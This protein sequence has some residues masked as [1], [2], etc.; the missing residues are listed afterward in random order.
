MARTPAA[1]PSIR[2]T[3]ARAGRTLVAAALAIGV[4]GL[5]GA[6]VAGASAP[7]RAG[8][9][10]LPLGVRTH[11]GWVKGL[12]TTV[13]REF[14]GIPYAAPP[15][16]ALRWRP[17]QPAAHWRGVRLAKKAGADC[18]QTGSLGTGVPTTSTAENCLFLNVYTPRSARPGLPVMVWIHGGGFTG[19]AARIYDGA[20]LAKKGHVIVVT[21]NYRLNAFGFLA[22]PSLDSEH[23]NS[24]GDYGLMDQ[25]AALRWVRDNARAF[26]G[27]PHSVTIFGESA[28]GAS[29]CANM[30]SPTAFG[31][32]A[33]A[34]AESGCLFPAQTKQA[35]DHQ[36]T[37]MAASLGC[38]H[39][40][41][42]AACLRRKSVSAILKADAAG[43]WGPVVSAPTLPTAPIT[44]FLKGHYDHVPLLQG[45]NHDEGRL[46][47]AL[48][49]GLPGGH[50]ITKKQY[51]TLI[52]GQFGA[53][54]GAQVLT[55][56][57]LSAYRSPNLA[58]SA[59]L[60]D[61]GFS[62]PALGAD[63][64]AAGSGVY[65]YEFSDPNPPNDFPIH[66]TLPLGAAHSTELQ[67][68][69][70]RIPFFDSVP[71]FKPAQLALSNQF[72]GYWTR[73]AASGN[74]NGGG[75]PVWPR[76]AFAKQ[77]IQELI[78]SAIAPETGAK[79]STFHKC[80]FW[81]AVEGG[82]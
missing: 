27:N 48:Q 50:P 74:P 70:Q 68:V 53:K 22:L 20:V 39:P 61:S 76:F 32:F 46:F 35:A 52:K 30:A 71:P 49:F 33:R 15:V 72:I 44:A 47:V 9:S 59:V 17:P 57:P 63:V 38:T 75:A 25:Q 26:G 6:G 29:V 62:C 82:R 14:L 80:S 13:A 41:T 31:L 60:T 11:D 58:Y 37:T 56:Y 73:F 4:T 51:P 36:G 12:R 45:T 81:L 34:I 78:P 2:T 19:G 16:G 55:K 24:S 42:A 64:L 40:A 1:S 67:Y 79:F 18:A 43:S 7:D 5:T 28:G 10:L 21:I 8:T 54:V 65:G 69:F 23:G 3:L 66:F 77:R